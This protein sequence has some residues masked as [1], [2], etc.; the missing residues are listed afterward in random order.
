[1]KKKGLVQVITAVM[2]VGML[3]GSGVNVFA[4]EADESWTSTEEKVEFSMTGVNTMIGED[5]DDYYKEYLEEKFNA[6]ITVKNN[7]F[8]GEAE[9]VSTAFIGGTMADAHLWLNF[10]W[11]GYYDYV[12]Q[13]MFAPLPKNW[14]VIYPNLANM[15]KASGYLEQVTVDGEVYALPHAI[16]GNLVKASTVTE[17][18]TVYL[19]KDLAAQ[20]GMEDLGEDGTVK[21]S[22]LKEYLE[23]LKENN[24]IEKATFGG[25]MEHL[26]YAFSANCGVPNADFL[27]TGSEYI[28]TPN[29]ENYETMLNEIREWYESGLL[30]ADFYQ[31]TDK[32][33]P[34]NEFN[35]GKRAVYIG[36]GSGPIANG[37]VE[38]VA[39]ECSL[40][41]DDLRL[42]I[43]RAEDD[44]VYA[45]ELGNYWT[46]TVFN[47]D[48]DEKVMA[49]ILTM[50]DWACTV[51]GQIYSQYGLPDVDWNYNEDGTVNII[52]GDNTSRNSWWAFFMLGWC[53]DDVSSS[54]L[55]PGLVMDEVQTQL[56]QI[57][58]QKENGVLIGLPKY[59]NAFSGNEKSAYSGAIDID[60]MAVKIAC[61]TDDIHESLQK[62]IEDNKGIWEPLV[63]AVEEKA[64]Y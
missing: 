6:D 34:Q 50:M 19:R 45:Y 58:E 4:A 18:F 30:D 1:M 48:I 13:G 24:L 27:D 14:E 33:T 59:Y 11:G 40:N 63:A 21:L 39:R 37:V 31:L 61:G 43:V 46:A 22:E 47:P 55:I 17:H 20:V 53:G 16:Y 35:A 8:E 29:V 12:D 23:K 5:Y 25:T 54:S 41:P 38:T 56:D 32:T 3:V 51:E 10:D 7:E 60:N 64:G 57:T 62:Y 15:V 2:S 26:L 44:T 42:A 28:W 49:R 52:N 9:R 36:E